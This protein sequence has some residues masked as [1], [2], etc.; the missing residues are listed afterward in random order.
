MIDAA[1]SKLLNEQ[2]NKEFY[3]AYLYLLFADYFTAEGLQG[4]ANWYLVQVQEE[5]A[6]AMLML[7]YMQNN[8][9]PVTLETIQK[10]EA[11]LL[12][13]LHVLQ[14][15][16]AHEQYVTASIHTIYEQAAQAKDYRSMQFLDWF[17]RE[18]DEEETNAETLIRKLTLFGGDA[19]GLYLLDQ[20]LGTR[21]F[22]PPSLKG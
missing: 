18:Q 15:G 13:H 14:A 6:H 16:L 4:F 17:I 21:V 12:S 11:S 2:I 10:P 8:R 3:S 22:N 5:N 1:I 20:E 19:K 9:Q 7:Q